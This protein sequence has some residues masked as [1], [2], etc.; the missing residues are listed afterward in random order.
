MGYL[1]FFQGIAGFLVGFYNYLEILA[2]FYG[3]LAVSGMIL[4]S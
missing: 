2:D 1:G 3:I 4:R